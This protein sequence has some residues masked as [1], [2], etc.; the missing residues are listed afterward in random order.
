[1]P[2]NFNDASL[3][4]ACATAPEA[5]VERA[6]SRLGVPVDQLATEDGSVFVVAEP[7]R[8]VSYAELVGDRTF[9][10]PLNPAARRKHS[11]EWRVLGTP[12][13]RLDAAALVTGRF[14]D[15][16]D[17]RVEGM[18]HGRV[19]RP[20]SPGSTLMSVDEASIRDVPGV[21]KVVVKGNFVGVVAEKAWQ[22]VQAAGKLHV[23]WTPGDPLPPQDELYGYLRSR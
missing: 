1:H 23:T 16:H 9:D 8:R 4:L 21:V 13:R 22:A 12:I 10:M 5:L 3:A 11:S 2:A 7:S 19:V 6:A 20:P 14:E 17:A 18:L 15:V